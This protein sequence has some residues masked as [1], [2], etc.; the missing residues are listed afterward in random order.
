[1]RNREGR[2]RDGIRGWNIFVRIKGWWEGKRNVEIDGVVD[3]EGLLYCRIEGRKLGRNAVIWDVKESAVRS[4]D[5]GQKSVANNVLPRGCRSWGD[6]LRS[7]GKLCYFYRRREREREKLR[8]DCNYRNVAMRISDRIRFRKNS[9]LKN[10]EEISTHWRCNVSELCNV[11][12][13]LRFTVGPRSTM[14]TVDGDPS[15]TWV[16]TVLIVDLTWDSVSTAVYGKLDVF[17]SFE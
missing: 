5:S 6:G 16:F 3:G 4:V 9:V 7:A 13:F 15:W 2:L 14:F 12:R 10:L 1:M 8:V 11:K 17:Y